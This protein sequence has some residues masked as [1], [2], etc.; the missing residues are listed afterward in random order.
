MV[1]YSVMYYFLSLFG[2]EL[3]VKNEKDLDPEADTP[4]PP[5]PPP[6]VEMATEVGSMHPT[7]SLIKMMDLSDSSSDELSSFLLS[8]L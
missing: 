2:V 6:K 1:K 7:V 5:C 3:A 8:Q 4:L